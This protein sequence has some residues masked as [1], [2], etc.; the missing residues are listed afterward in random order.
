ML[1]HPVWKN[2]RYCPALGLESRRPW[3]EY[4]EKG[5][6]DDEFVDPAGR[7]LAPRKP[8]FESLENVVKRTIVMPAAVDKAAI[9]PDPEFAGHVQPPAL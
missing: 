9:L 4:S 2:G 1:G 5:R 8:P 6:G 3:R 7:S